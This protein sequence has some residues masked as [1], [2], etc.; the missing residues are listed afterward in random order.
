M[1][2]LRDVRREV[3]RERH[4]LGGGSQSLFRK[5]KSVATSWSHKFVCLDSRDAEKVSTTQSSRVILEEA[6]LGE[7]VSTN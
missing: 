3:H 6:G 2:N 1:S 4:S 5:R 7:K